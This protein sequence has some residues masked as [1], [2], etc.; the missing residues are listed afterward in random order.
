[1]SAFLDRTAPVRSYGM[2]VGGAWRQ[3]ADAATIDSCDPFTGQVWATIP[4]ATSQDVDDAVSAA[5]EALVPWSHTTAT[6]RGRRLSRFAE[7]VAEHA[8]DLA[9]CEVRDVGKLLRD[10]RRQLAA[11]PDWYAY[12]AGAADKVEGTTIPSDLPD[13]FV[14]TRREPV[15]VVAAVTPWNSPLQLLA[16]KLGPALAAGCTVVVKPPEQAS[17]STLELASLFAEAGFPPGVV[18]V[19]T[20]TGPAAGEALVASQRVAKVAFTGSTATGARIMA[21]AARN[22]TEVSL[23]LGG[24]SPNIVFADAEPGAIDGVVAGIFRAAGQRCV[25]GSRVLVQRQAHEEFTAAFV[26][27][28]RT[29]RLG[30]PLDPDTTMGPLAFAA[31]L[32]HV[33]RLI[34][35]ARQEGATVACGGRRPDH[36]ALADGFFIEPTVLSGVDNGMRHAREEIF[37]PVVSLLPFDDE[38][39]A[40]RIANDS[41]FGLAAGVWTAD[42]GRAHRMAHGLNAG[43]VWLNAYGPLSVT[44][45]FGG[46]KHSGLGAEAGVDAVAAYTRAKSVWINMTSGPLPI[47]K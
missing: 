33:E 40:L 17:V 42:L 15:G 9:A 4:A 32:D 28:T 19:I 41:N 47:P 36:P 24:K 1:M 31:H 22:I 37:G 38:A 30:D 7:L 44:T 8:D 2:L 25:A 14:Y 21:S 3:A 29:I 20:G 6:E 43:T 11:L 46:F 26:E 16:T 13:F 34:N 5:A 27:R 12:F 10:A 45:P 23:E 35:V 18:N 39:D